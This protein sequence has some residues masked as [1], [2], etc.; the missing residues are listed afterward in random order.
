MIYRDF[1][2]PIT[3]LCM[4][5]VGTGGSG[6]FILGDAFLQNVVVEFD[7]ANAEIH[8]MSRPYY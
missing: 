4:T 6:P 2:D 8:F 7:I 3:G 5:A 1:R